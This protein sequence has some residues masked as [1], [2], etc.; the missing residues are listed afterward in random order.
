[1]QNWAQQSQPRVVRNAQSPQ[2]VTGLT[3]G[4]TYSITVNGRKSGGPGGDGSP[5]ISFV[6]RLAGLAWALG[7]PLQAAE[8]RGL[9]FAAAFFPGVYVTVGSAGSAFIS[10][11]GISWTA[12]TTGVTTQ[13]NATT[14]G[15]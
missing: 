14:H 4:T 5:S 8:L 7:T 13:L 15:A 11:D 6:P 12:V 9:G 10:A 1:P 2:I 3:N